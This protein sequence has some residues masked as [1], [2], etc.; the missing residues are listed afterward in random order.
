MSERKTLISII[1]PVYG[2]PRLIRDLV[3]EIEKSVRK[4]TNEYEIILVEDHSPDDSAMIIR[5]L[6]KENP[7]VKGVILS[8]NFGQQYALN[9]GL[10]LATGEWVITLDCD[11]QNPPSEIPNLYM[12]AKEGYDIVYASRQERKDNIISRYG[13]YIFNKVLSF[14]TDTS[15]DNTIAEFVIYNRRVVDAMKQMGDYVR[16]YPLMSQWVGYN[17][18][19]IKVLQD[20]RNDGIKSSYSFAKRLKLAISTAISFST[21]PLKL[22]V[23]LGM[24]MVSFAIILA[25]VM[26]L[27]YIFAG[28]DVSGWLTLFVSLWFIAGIMIMIIGII[29]IY[30][31]QVYEEVKRRPSYIVAEKLNF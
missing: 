12:K 20:E 21:K 23:V 26:A 18:T 16:Y 5:E 27:Q 10:D 1:S 8:R 31:S 25:I 6:C 19:K 14:L 28:I 7:K 17:F 24:A 15:Q 30:L 3:S 11:L 2:A 4:I 29:A 22:I 9:A 13:S